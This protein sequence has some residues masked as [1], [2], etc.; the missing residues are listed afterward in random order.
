MLS[1]FRRLINSKVGLFVTF[2]ALIL[3]A[4]AFAAGDVTGLGSGSF[5]GMTGTNVATVGRR[6]VTAADLRADAQ[7]VMDGYR[8]QYPQLTMAEFVDKGGLD[9]ALEGK[10]NSLAVEAFGNSQGMRVGKA[11]IDN[12]IATAPSLQGLDGKFDMTRYR[13]FLAQQKI[14]DADLHTQLARS[15]IEAQLITPLMPQVTGP[16]KAPSTMAIPYASMLLEKRTGTVAFIPTP[17]AAAGA[18][19]TD[20]E[21]QTYYRRNVARYSLP[22]R[23][24]VRYA[25]IAIADLRQRAAPTDAEIAKAYQ[26]QAARFAAT[27]NR[28]FHQVVLLDQKAA[29]AL[30]A[31][32][33]GGTSIA[34]AAKAAG[35]DAS[36]ASDVGKAAYAGQT[37]PQLA[38]QAFAASAGAVLGP[39]KIPLGWVV[40]QLDKITKVPAKSLDQAKPDLVKE[41]TDKKLTVIATD[42]RA[43]I[44]DAITNDKT[45][46]EIAKQLNLTVQVAPPATAQGVDPEAKTP[47][48][49]D[50]KLAPFYQLAFQSSPGDDP[51][52]I[53]VSKEGDFALAKLDRVVPAAPRPFATVAEQVKKDLTIDRQVAAARVAAQGIVNK[54]NAGTQLAQAMGQSGLK[55]PDTKP[56]EANRAQLLV[57]NG[58]QPVPPPLVL[59]FNTAQGK[60]RLLEAPYKGGWFVVV[61]DTIQKGDA[62]GKADIIAKMQGDLGSTAGEEYRQQFTRAIRKAVGVKKNATAISEVRAELLGQSGGQ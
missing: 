50:P 47:T 28:S 19:A 58:N 46:D 9:F 25:L 16:I 36:A 3:L 27:E 53:P 34:D 7:R 26:D 10:I 18:P 29:E 60:A 57:R 6:S 30:A 12:E 11:L 37:S 62:S 41:L 5:G 24:S 43:Q 45:I 38:D 4:L 2:A 61:V 21:M 14:S 51:Q 55:L 22:E 42:L 15:M 1:F 13:E 31:K 17:A 32:V 56:M 59:L 20:A 8:R 23:R 52:V 44:D 40:V 48:P 33:R 54:V 39:V 35:L 49:P